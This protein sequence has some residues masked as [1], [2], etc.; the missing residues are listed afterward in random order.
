M[1]KIV[2]VVLTAAILATL[3]A[4]ANK[5]EKAG[6]TQSSTSAP[7][8]SETSA[9]RV[10]STTEKISINDEK[11]EN[12]KTSVNEFLGNK[13][14][15]EVSG[16]ISQGSFKYKYARSAEVIYA[17]EREE[18]MEYTFQENAKKFVDDVSVFYED[19]IT[20]ESFDA[21]TISSGENG[22]DSVIYFAYYTNTQN[23]LLE[24]QGNSDGVINYVNCNFTW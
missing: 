20:L 23:Q 7:T 10:T 9:Q 11:G 18:E 24:I 8:S 5:F 2:C 21:K 19:E 17:N 15:A 22:I 3:C 12:L 13:D 14:G 1:K 4:C 16:N 6:Q